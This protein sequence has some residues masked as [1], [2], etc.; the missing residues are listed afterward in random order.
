MY[1]MYVTY[2]PLGRVE[3][4]TST[5]VRQHWR[6]HLD[7]ASA[8]LPVA[9][10]RGAESFS[11]VSSS[12]LQGLLRRSI[13]A[14]VVVAEDD[15]WSVFLDGYPIAADGA[16]LDEALDDF[17]VSLTD[18]TDAWVDRLHTVSNHQDAAP[19]ALLVESSS[20]DELRE[21]A[22]GSVR[23]AASA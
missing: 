17:I 21:W 18:Y 16:D 12:L 10:S 1:S 2:R 4:E 22:R 23:T 3:V 15:G 9:F 5:E 19:L 11:V 20:P 8:H 13:P 6:A 14:P 7:R